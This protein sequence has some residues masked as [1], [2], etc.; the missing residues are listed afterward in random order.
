VTITVCLAIHNTRIPNVASF[1]RVAVLASTGKVIG[2]GHAATAPTIET[3]VTELAGLRE[4]TMDTGPV[5]FVTFTGYLIS[6]RR[7]VPT[8]LARIAST[9]IRV[10]AIL[11]MVYELVAET[12]C[13][14]IRFLDTLPSIQASVF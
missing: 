1:P 3:R 8:V 14:R 12:F 10:L 11:S 5:H 4:L 13:L 6:N 9:T 7:A 2:I